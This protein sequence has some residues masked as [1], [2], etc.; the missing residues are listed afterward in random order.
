MKTFEQFNEDIQQRRQELHQRRL[1]QMKAQRE[2]I[3]D[4]QATQKN[5]IQKQR[6]R[7]E[8]KK[9]IKRELRTDQTPSMEP[10]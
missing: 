5:K 6:E 10:N 2:R 4:Y 8:L 3:A 1:D 9:E 7:E